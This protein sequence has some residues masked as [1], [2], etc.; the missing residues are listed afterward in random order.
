MAKFST[1]KGQDLSEIVEYHED[2][3]KSLGHAFDSSTP[4]F[5]QRYFGNTPKEMHIILF[6][7][8]NETGIRSALAILASVEAALRIDYVIRANRRMKDDLSRDFR[9][10]YKESEERVRL[11]EDILGRWTD[12]HPEF[13]QLVGELRGALNFRD[14][15][16]HGRYWEPKLGRKYDYDGIYWIANLILE[17]FPLYQN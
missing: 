7:R 5:I 3:I 12:R 9:A 1:L 11:S 10:L 2:V 14:W 16:A 4:L 13:K 15:I 6:N 8:I 17:S